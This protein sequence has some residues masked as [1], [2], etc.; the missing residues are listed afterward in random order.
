M[1]TFAL[2]ATS[3]VF[4]SMLGLGMRLPP[5]LLRE[6]IPKYGMIGRCLAVALVAVPI[7]AIALGESL[8]LSH[9]TYVGLLLVG[10]SPGAPLALRR[11]QDSGG[12]ASFAMALQV[13]LGIC[14][15]LAVPA[16]VLVVHWIYNATADIGL[17]ALA[18]QVATAQLLPL[19]LGAALASARPELATKASA[20]LLRIGAI[21]VILVVLIV[22]WKFGLKLPSLGVAAYLASA[23]LTIGALALGHWAGGPEPSRRTAAAVSCA[24]RN[25]G[26]ALLVASANKLLADATL[27]V[28]AH[29][30]LTTLLLFGYLALRPKAG[31]SS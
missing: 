23:L 26:I 1:N 5:N 3:A 28:L 29:V 7:L 13:L 31:A 21:M 14:A 30:L 25:P 2:F 18:R 12:K 20:P 11:S 24:M 19:G 27:M 8:G 6:E 9:A 16:W 15:I 22:L 10:I 17:L 4:V